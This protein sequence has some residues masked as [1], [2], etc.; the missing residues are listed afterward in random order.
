MHF[1]RLTAIPLFQSIGTK[2]DADQDRDP[3]FESGPLFPPAR[4]LYLKTPARMGMLDSV[5]QRF[6]VALDDR[7]SHANW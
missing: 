1:P 3:D 7:D 4:R 2:Y 5:D 6:N